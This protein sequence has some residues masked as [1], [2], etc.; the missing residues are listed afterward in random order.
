MISVKPTFI[1]LKVSS[2]RKFLI[3]QVINNTVVNIMIN[4]LVTK[5]DTDNGS[6]DFTVT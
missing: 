2:L 1:V 5:I 3:L 6:A 4:N